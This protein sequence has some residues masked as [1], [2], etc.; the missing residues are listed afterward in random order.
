M[1]A[2][3]VSSI[4]NIHGKK[5]EKTVVKCKHCT[6]GK[7]IKDGFKGGKQQYKCKDCGH[8]FT[9]TDSHPNMRFNRE[10][11]DASLGWYYE[12][13]SLRAVARQIRH[14]FNVKVYPSTIWRWIQKYVP[15][16]ND[17]VKRLKPLIGGEWHV[18]E[19]VVKV[20]GEKWWYWEVI[21]KDTRLILGTHLSRTRRMSDAEAV[22]RDAYL[23][24]KRLPITVVCDGL[25]AYYGGL[26]RALGGTTVYRKVNFNPNA[27]IDENNR[28]ERFHN[29][30]KAR[31]KVMRGLQN[32][33]HL[34]DG[35]CIYY[36]L[37]RPHMTLKQT[38]GEFA[39]LEVPK[40]N[41]WGE[42]I[43]LATAHK[44]VLGH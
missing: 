32:P 12:G 29:T 30:L 17:F 38:P 44:T 10:I 43:E 28:I 23:M 31:Y 20:S 9:N 15:L 26:K 35:F 7:V 41:G 13:M 25:P 40:I 6:L 39:M 5:T 14:L 11:V 34:L 33:R 27:T 22:F 21:D 1:S 16:V 18:D 3:Q 36:N 4:N 8:K 24:A 37:I 19:T 42:L 2:S